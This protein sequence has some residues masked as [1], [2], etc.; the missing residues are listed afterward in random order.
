MQTHQF[1]LMLLVSALDRQ[2]LTDNSQ[3][4][5]CLKHTGGDVKLFVLCYL[6]ASTLRQNILR[7]LYYHNGEMSITELVTQTKSTH[8]EVM[9][10]V[11]IYEGYAIVRVRRIDRRVYVGLNLEKEEMKAL[12]N[13]LRFLESH[14]RSQRAHAFSPD[15]FCSKELIA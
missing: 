11:R 5:I 1:I 15:S 10:N 4:Q 8:S 12:L 3:I 7:V 14:K 13:A 6:V 9:R 2:R